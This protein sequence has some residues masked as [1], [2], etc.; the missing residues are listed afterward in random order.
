MGHDG[1]RKLLDGWR[2]WT[3]EINAIHHEYKMKRLVAE[4]ALD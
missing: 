2:D 3:D 1:T 4:A